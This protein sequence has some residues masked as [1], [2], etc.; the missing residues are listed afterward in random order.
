MAESAAF[1]GLTILGD[2]DAAIC[3][4]GVC[5]IPGGAATASDTSEHAETAAP[6]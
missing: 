4:D 2:S 6:G 3:V 5:H 1:P